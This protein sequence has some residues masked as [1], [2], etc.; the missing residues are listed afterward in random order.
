MKGYQIKKICFSE[1]FHI[2][3]GD[4]APDIDMQTLREAFAPFGEIA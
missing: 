2:F 4:L 1:S 3:V